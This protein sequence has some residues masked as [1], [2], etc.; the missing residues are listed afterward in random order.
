MRTK[1][2]NKNPNV[3]FGKVTDTQNRPLSGLVVQVYD[4]DMRTETLLAET[5]TDSDGKYQVTWLHS[6][7]KSPEIKEADI[8]VKV[9]TPGNRTLLYSTGMDSV[10][11][12]ASPR[13]EINIIIQGAIAPEVVEYDYVLKTVTFL[14]DKVAVTD[15]QENSDNQDITFISREADID[16][17]KVEYMVVAQ[18]LQKLSRINAA[19]FYALLREDTLLKNTRS[20]SLSSRISIGINADFQLLLYDAALVDPQV[21]QSDVDAAVKA[22]IVSAAVS[23]E[24]PRDIELLSQYRQKAEEYYKTEYPKKALDTVTR[25][26]AAGKIQEAAKLFQENIN[27]MNAFFQKI[28]DSSFF[29]T[30]S[31]ATDARTQIDLGKLLGFGSE[32]IPHLMKSKKIRKPEDVR[33]LAR[34]NKSQWVAELSKIKG[35]SNLKADDKRAINTY[36][37]AVVR[38]FESAYPTTAFAAQLEREKATVLRNQDH[39]VSFLNKHEDFDL[40]RHNVDVF[41]REKKVPAN[42]SA[43]V[44]DELKSVQRVFKLVPNYAKTNALRSQNIQSAQSIV[45]SG[46]SRFVNEIAPKAGINETEAKKIFTKAQ[47]INTASMLIVGQLHDIAGAAGIAS[48]NS[49]SLA[50]KLEAV[51]Q[52]FP[53][54]KSLFK[55]TDTCACED[56]RSVDG[57]AAYLVEILQFLEK[58]RVTDLTVTPHITGSLAK[59]VLFERRPELGDIDLSCDNAMTPVKYI[60]LVCELL[61]DAVAPQVGIDF[62]GNLS[63]GA[64]PLLGTISAG[65]LAAV[66]GAGLPVTDKA[67]VFQTEVL[68]G[69]P[70]TLTHYLRDTKVVCKIENTGGNNYKVYQLR[71]T[72]STAD[73]LAA[74]PEYVNDAAYTELAAQSFAFKLP[75]DLNETEAK[76][77]FERFDISRSQ[78]MEDFQLAGNPPDAAIAAEKLGLTDSERNLIVTAKPTL[79]DQELI[80]NAPAQW[81]NPPI[82]GNVVDYMKRVDHFLDKTGLSY[83]DLDLLLKLKFIDPVNSLFIKNLDL[84]CDTAKKEIANLNEDTL[85]R[86][87]RFLRLQKKTG[88]RLDVLDSIISQL[89][90]G[91]GSLDD[92]LIIIAATLKKIVEATGIKVD[93]LIGFYDEIPHD[94]LTDTAPKPLYYQVFLNKA[95]NGFID[96]GMLPE[97]VDGSQLIVGF[98]TSISAYLQM[99]QPDLERL[100]PLLPDDKLT[101]AN[102]SYLLAASRLTKKLKLKTPDYLV[103]NEL[104]GLNITD[105]PQATLDFIKLV[106]NFSAS[107]LKIADVLFMLRHEAA[108]LPDLS[109]KIRQTLQS[110]QTSYQNNFTLNKSKFDDTLSAQE[111]TETLQNELAGLAGIAEDDEKT[112]LKFINKDWVSAADAK[113]FTDDKLGM[114]DTT[115][116]KAAIDTLDAAVGPDF[117]A[118]EKALVKAFLDSISVFKLE[119]GKQLIL[120]QALSSAFKADP[121]LV[122]V[123]LKYAQLKQPAPN[124]GLIAPILES[125]TLIDT[126]TSHVTPVLPAIT[127][128]GFP[129]QYACLKLLSKLFPLVSAFQLS[130]EQV[131]WFLANNALLGWFGLDSIPN[132]IGQ[133]SVDYSEYIAF[134]QLVGLA[135]QYTPVVNPADAENPVTFFSVAKMLLPGSIATRDQFI[136]ALSVL[137]GYDNDILNAVDAY[138]F[139]IFDFNNYKDVGNWNAL[140]TG[141][142]YLWKL[143]SDMGQVVQYLKPVLLAGDVSTLRTTLKS[144]YDEDTWLGTLK[145]IMDAIR[146][147]KRDALVAYLLA[148]NPDMKDENDLFDYFLIDV[149]MESCMPSSRIVQAHGTVQLFVQRC[150]MGLEPKASADLDNDADWTQWQWMK[151]YR[152][153][154]ANRKVFLYPENWLAPDLRDNK[155]FLFTEFENELKQN[156]L[157]DVTAEN[158]LINYLEKLDN[159][160]FLE[161][162]ATWYQVDIRTMHVFART[163]GG[164]PATYY[165]RQFQQERYW[166]PW[167][168]VDLDI[169]G[170]QLLAFVRNNRLCLAWPVFSEVPDQGQK[171]TIP[172]ATAGAQVDNEKPKR[173]L[174]IQL[175]V[176]EY[177]N[178]KWQTKKISQDG[179]LTPATSTTEELPKDLYNLMYFELAQQVW[180]FTNY[181]SGNSYYGYNEVDGIFNLNGCKGYPEL[182]FQGNMS[183]ADFLPDFKDTVFKSQRYFEA[184]QIAGDDLSVRNAMSFLTFYEILHT[185]PGNFR[186]TYPMQITSIDLV[187]LI[188]EYLLMLLLSSYLK[189]QRGRFKIP[190]GTMLPYFDEDS[191]HAYVIVPGFYQKQTD[192]AGVVTLTDTEKRTASDVFQL[193]DDIVNLVGKFVEIYNNANPKPDANTFI[194][195]IVTDA[196]FQNVVNELAAYEGFDLL[197]NFLIGISGN[198]EIDRVLTE[199]RDANGL[200]YGEQFK[201]MYH[202]LVCALR[203]TLNKY[204][205]PGLMKRETQLQKTAFNFK[206]NYN[207]NVLVVPQSLYP[208]PDGT[209]TLSY[210]IEDLDFASDGSYSGY[211]WELFFHVPFLLATRLT[212]NQ[213]FEDALTWFHYMFNP[214][215]ALSGDTPQKYWV[216]KPFFLNQDS[217]Y[218]DQ[219]IDNLLYRIA[220]P[221]T[222]E[223]KELE[224]AIEQWRNNPFKPDVVARF[225]PVAYQKALLMKYIDNLVQWGDYLFGQDTMEAIAQATQMYILADKLL[226][227]KPRIIPS[228]VKPPYETYNQIEAKLD[229]FGN[230][231]IDLENIIPDLSVLPEGGNELPTPPLTLSMLY[232]CVP[233][234]SDMLA[235]WD[236]VADRLFKI[237][238]CQNIDGVE[239]SLALFAPPI[240]PGILVRA[241]ASGLSI[242]DVLAGLNAPT[243]YYRFNVLSQKATELAQEVRTLGSALLQA[244]EKKDAESMALLRSE[245]EINVLNAVKDMKQLQI[246]EATEQIEVLNR[247]RKVTEERQKFYSTIQKI[248]AKEQLNLDKLDES[249]AFQTA[250]QGVKLAASIISLLPD[251]NLGASGFGGSPL[252]AFKIGGLNI[253]QATNAAS[254]ILSFLGMLA[255]NEASRASILGS[256]DRRFDDWK[257]QERLAN[258]ELDSIDKQISAAQIRNDIA[259][260]DLRN[261]Q[262]QIDNAKKTDEFMRSKFTN[263]DLYD[264]MISQ[265]SSVYFSAYKLSHDLAKKAERSYRFELGNDDSF[266]SYGYWDSVKKGLQSADQL[267]HD[268]KRMGTSYLDKNKREYEITKHVSL[269]MLDSLAL[270][271]LRATG[272][273]DFEIPEVLYDLDFPGQYFRRIKSVSISLPCVAGPYTSVSAK[274]SL[275]NNRYRKNTHP[276]N[277]A[278]TGYAED[279][280]NDERFVYNV[281]AIQSIAA[282]NSQNDSGVFELNFRDE[283]YLPFEGTGAVSSW[284]LELPTEVKQ[285]DYATISDVIVHVKYT[286]REGGS[287]LKTLANAIL[288]DQLAAMKQ[289]LS[290][291]GLHVAINLKNDQPNEWY[292]LKTNNTVDLTIDKSR[293]P[294]MV[295]AF[296]TAAIESVMFVANVKGNPASYSLN[297]DGA[298]LNLS[299]IDELKLCTGINSTIELGTAFTVFGA[300]ADIAKLDGLLMVVKYSF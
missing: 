174:M 57:P 31:A 245:L 20:T 89:K 225:R 123:V 40:T 224:F 140:F 117:S 54:L 235:Y 60:D 129:K 227:P 218:N 221:T 116:I 85:D 36:A 153:W 80:W 215:G 165:Y 294:Y 260:T 121:D 186:L 1:A 288:K 163:K 22:L 172:P 110:L 228:P 223:R 14:A 35:K 12:N 82:A 26:I 23:K 267:L 161:V 51:S 44:K 158:A 7:L 193:F 232:F 295:Q 38:K 9:L 237:R 156:E 263:K 5:T 226:G 29:S 138:R 238:H 203:I 188:F 137:T 183:F 96:E 258:R 151:N 107:P 139:P 19:F 293:L 120:G 157:T 53:N 103:F 86:V 16:S 61:E 131:D 272:V 192:E 4:Q 109:V 128:L 270:I 3:V 207:P 191:N 239:R 166:T 76:A 254:D 127:E 268:I 17:E 217:D 63:D 74:A 286:A 280:G 233:P 171:S 243:P 47:T 155:S 30:A 296:D 75:F 201:N 230:A 108:I 45:T 199:L 273:T 179:I 256:Y 65:L 2:D 124:S 111:Q 79:V 15:L 27:D 253:G 264:W 261:H 168:K 212:S 178:N 130:N 229:A 205:I 269:A 250:A 285:F 234:N 6:Q 84:S 132:D 169:S 115:A 67:Q 287:S 97:K 299:R 41:L 194:H 13:E 142:D 152:V 189:D 195:E 21:I 91:N 56:C 59:E 46:Q 99:K 43:P 37:S 247:T 251:I 135:K 69:A 58:R 257:L 216:T 72:L 167:E 144:R 176:S 214:T 190:M 125:D 148:V 266:I 134:A 240:D 133:L 73:E 18:N 118:E 173:K 181:S 42:E 184:N 39:I 292:L 162:M 187:A 213:R 291:E 278:A 150:L 231:L 64:N 50:K 219:L 197:W 94:I 34:L 10:R 32:V 220:D 222:P 95:K 83:N 102:L 265:I 141:A 198:E 25:F 255:A 11:F 249:H 283:R 277:A 81:D 204:G 279:P 206:N 259:V 242:S 252:A 244:L 298:V 87:H 200:V 297:V 100:L 185:T 90:L 77:Y 248:S 52:D 289:A 66:Q 28:T 112:F 160:A 209:K 170:D 154:E 78:L 8:A 236:T 149:E 282:S 126:D 196:D 105:S 92:R 88:W 101:F 122:N 55:L 49:V 136:E 119:S 271:R 262:L 290:E 202:P 104:S 241:A 177:S 284:H 274:L 33:K 106:N 281:G 210:P 159:I 114:L 208:N 24:C 113:N 70:D 143:G 71:Q 62:T 275:V 175:A 147:H 68:L 246:Q 48:L 98:A 276:D 180:F 93:E 146:P 211:N 182:L 145:E 300:G 164:D